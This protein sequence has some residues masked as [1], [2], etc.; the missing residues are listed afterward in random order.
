M[1]MEVLWAPTRSI[2]PL[3]VGS[4]HYTVALLDST[5][6]FVGALM[7]SWLASWLAGHK[8]VSVLDML[9][10]SRAVEEACMRACMELLCTSRTLGGLARTECSM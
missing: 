3:E 6:A 4:G 8:R 7:Q 5:D 2:A 9:E 10:I 1:V